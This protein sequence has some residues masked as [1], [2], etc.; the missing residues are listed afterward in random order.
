MYSQQKMPTWLPAPDGGHGTGAAWLREEQAAAL[1]VVAGSWVDVARADVV[2]R[3]RVQIDQ[4]VPEDAIM[5]DALMVRRGV[6]GGPASTQLTPL[7]NIPTARRVV[8]RLERM[9]RGARTFAEEVPI[10]SELLLRVA[11]MALSAGLEVRGS[12]YLG[13]IAVD[14]VEPT[15]AAAALVTNETIVDIAEVSAAAP[16]LAEDEIDREDPHVAGLL[17]LLELPMRHGHLFESSN[18]RAPGGVLLYG[19]PG[20][21]KTHLVRTVSAAC[22]AHL[23][24]INGPEILSPYPGERHVTATLAPVF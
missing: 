21:G 4:F 20:V 15:A 13:V 8:V 6:A 3:C 19:P 18:L 1:G 9:P 10:M 24:S 5:V 17:S 14:R 22:G 16:P 12:T 7:F 11:G 23:V 2:A